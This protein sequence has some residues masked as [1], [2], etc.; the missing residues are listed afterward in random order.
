[1]KASSHVPKTYLVKVAGT[2][3][4]DGLTKLRSGVYI[5]GKGGRRQKTAP[6]RI[7]P[8]R[9]ADNPWYEVKL[10]GLGRLMIVGL[11]GK[12]F[13]AESFELRDE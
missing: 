4:A 2:P 12:V 11:P 9:E 10:M 6:A 7:K 5:Q 3:S 1:M 8:I 13:S